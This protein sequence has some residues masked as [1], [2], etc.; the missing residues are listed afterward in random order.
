MDRLALAGP[1]GRGSN[2]LQ[3]RP[4]RTVGSPPRMVC[5]LPPLSEPF[6]QSAL[7]EREALVARYEECRER[8][9]ALLQEASDAAADADRYLATI[10]ELGELLGVEDQLSIVS[11][12]EEL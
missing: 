9:E 3:V 5:P 4:A 6:R 1:A 7:I 2:T 12:A 8:H 10:R 11:L